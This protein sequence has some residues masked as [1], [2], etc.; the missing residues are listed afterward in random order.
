MKKKIILFLGN[1][2]KKTLAQNNITKIDKDNIGQVV[3]C[4]E[5][6]INNIHKRN[7]PSD[8]KIFMVDKLNRNID[9]LTKYVDNVDTIYYDAEE[10]DWYYIW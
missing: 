7:I 3:K 9:T 1:T 10:E 6:E 5:E 2:T 4:L 8:K